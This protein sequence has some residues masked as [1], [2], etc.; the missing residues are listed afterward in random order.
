MGRQAP[1]G[2]VGIHTNLLVAALAIADMLPA[3]SEQER[4]AL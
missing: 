3:E 4:G 2:P 1:E